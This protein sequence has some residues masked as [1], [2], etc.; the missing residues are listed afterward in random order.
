MTTPEISNL[1]TSAHELEVLALCAIV[2][3]TMGSESDQLRVMSN[4]ALEE[5]MGITQSNQ[6]VLN[7]GSLMLTIARGAAN[8]N[9]PVEGITDTTGDERGSERSEDTRGEGGSGE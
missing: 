5:L 9:P 3:G 8:N 6:D 7:L 2:V 1:I 4:R